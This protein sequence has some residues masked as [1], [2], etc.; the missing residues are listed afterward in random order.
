MSDGPSLADVFKTASNPLS[1]AR[2][3]HR[4]GHRARLDRIMYWDAQEERTSGRLLIAWGTWMLKH[5]PLGRHPRRGIRVSTGADRKSPIK[6]FCEALGHRD[7][8]FWASRL[9]AR[10][11]PQP[12]WV[13]VDIGNSMDA[14][15]LKWKELTRIIFNE[16]CSDKR[17]PRARKNVRDSIG[18]HLSRLE[19]WT[20]T[21]L[22]PNYGHLMVDMILRFLRGWMR[23]HQASLRMFFVDVDYQSI[24]RISLAWPPKWEAVAGD[25]VQDLWECYGY[26]C[27]NNTD[28]PA[29][30]RSTLSPG[31]GARW[32]RQQ[33][34]LHFRMPELKIG[35][36]QWRWK[37]SDT[38]AL[39]RGIITD[40]KPQRL[41]ILGD[42]LM[43]AGCE[44]EEIIRYC[45]EDLEA[46]PPTN[47][48][49]V[50]LASTSHG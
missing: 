18:R 43:D 38:V 34:R 32:A 20:T 23:I 25:V 24:Q 10:L 14:L 19:Q 9:Q 6:L 45:R 16:D 41:P 46:K 50:W 42:A 3:K 2:S 48:L 44:R 5:L 21:F 49:T 8:A 47:W 40:A 4:S 11:A 22:N 12:G 37:T 35:K 1:F 33:Y 30:V 13:P 29:G 17:I 39:A 15:L 36:E 28:F 31:V 26:L 7:T 27:G